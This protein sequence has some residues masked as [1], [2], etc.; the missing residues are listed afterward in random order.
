M[1][2]PFPVIAL[3]VLFCFAVGCQDKT[4]IAEFKQMKAQAEVEAQNKK[5]AYLEIDKLWNE[6]NLD[7]ADQVYAPNQILHFRGE[8]YPFGPDAA[9]KV[10][11]TWLKAFPDFKFKIEDMVAEGDK[12]TIRYVFSGTHQGKFWGIAPTGKKI[13]V[14]QMNIVRFE[15]GKMVEAWENYDEYGMKLQLGMELMLKEVKK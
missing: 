13:N 1:K 9:K 14:S 8:S 12:V 6:G 4:A 2:K 3:V 15:K 5:I 11:S 7:V 10:V